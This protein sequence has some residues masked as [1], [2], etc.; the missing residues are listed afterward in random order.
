MLAFV[1]IGVLVFGGLGEEERGEGNFVCCGGV[2]CCEMG[3]HLDCE[4]SIVI[5]WTAVDSDY[6]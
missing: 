5:L 3:K 6:W 1:A 2:C 4:G